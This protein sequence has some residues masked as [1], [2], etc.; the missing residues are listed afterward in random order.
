MLGSGGT[1]VRSEEGARGAAGA[2]TE[3]TRPLPAQASN[4][5]TPLDGVVKFIPDHV[6][7]PLP[8]EAE[9]QSALVL[10]CAWREVLVRLGFLGQAPDRYGGVGF[11][12]MSARLG[13]D[14][15]R[16]FLAS[17]TQTSGKR[18]VTGADFCVVERC[19]VADNR[20]HSLGPVLPSS[21]TM[22]HGAIYALSDDIRFVFHGHAPEIW[23]RAG[24]LGLVATAPEVEYGTVAMANEMD[25]LYRTTALPAQRLLCM[26]GH[27]DGVLTFG[28]TAAEAG[29]PWARTLAGVLSLR[30]P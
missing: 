22:T 30:A 2:T 20:V 1:V 6:F 7:A 26:L 27:E 5:E 17:G 14:P 19:D 21:E 12:N 28:A 25:R 16:R 18:L 8:Q 9:V 13:A 10:L 15:S 3:V 11:G 23:T 29:E 24:H 4:A